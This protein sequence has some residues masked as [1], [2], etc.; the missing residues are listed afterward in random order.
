M[1][2]LIFVVPLIRR[3]H[4]AGG[5]VEMLAVIRTLAT[6]CCYR[7]RN[8]SLR[9]G[10]FRGRQCNLA[11]GLRKFGVR[12]PSQSASSGGRGL[13]EFTMNYRISASV[14]RLPVFSLRMPRA[15]RGSG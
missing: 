4:F 6:K 11:G 7:D 15:E 12:R 5:P 3:L 8:E 14:C 2:M 13:Q 1:L 10:R 9:C